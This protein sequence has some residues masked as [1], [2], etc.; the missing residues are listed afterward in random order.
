MKRKINR[1]MA[2]FGMGIFIAGITV[3]SSVIL[4]NMNIVQTDNNIVKAAE[5]KT[6]TETIDGIEWCYR[7]GYNSST[8]VY[9]VNKDT[10]PDEVIIPDKLGGFPVTHIGDK[11]FSE[12]K[13]KS[14]T[15][16]ETVDIIGSSAFADCPNLMTI[17]L[18]EKPLSAAYE[19][20]FK[21]CKAITDVSVGSVFASAFEGCTNLKT[22]KMP[23][24]FNTFREIKSRGFKGCTSLQEVSIDDS[25]TSVTVGSY[26]F[27]GCT[28]LKAF[29]V[30]EA[31]IVLGK[32]AF[33]D[34]TQ[35]SDI[36]FKGN[37]TGKAGVFKNCISLTS[38][39]FEKNATLAYGSFLGCA[40]LEGVTFNGNAISSFSNIANSVFEGCSSLKKVTF[41][42]EKA[43]V[44]FN[45]NT[46]VEEIVYNNTKTISGGL[47][48]VNNLKKVRFDTKNPDLS[49]FT[50][51]DSGNFIIE[52]YRENGTNITFAG[53]DTVYQWAA[54]NNLI[55]SF[56]SLGTFEEQ[57]ETQVTTQPS[58]T[59]API[60][61]SY[62]VTFDG[63]GGFVNGIIAKFRQEVIYGQTYGTLK[64]A[65]RKGYNFKGW[66]TQKTGGDRIT[67]DTK[68]EITEN[69]TLYAQWEKVSVPQ[70]TIS[71]LINNKSKKFTITIKKVSEAEGYEVLYSDSKNF[72]DINQKTLPAPAVLYTTPKLSKGQT[73]YVKVRAYKM[74]ST[75]SKV[76]GKYSS[77]KKI[78]IRK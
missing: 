32:F 75:G 35:F 9:P 33:S 36:V 42:G 8:Y 20:A 73:Y 38:L 2:A 17:K 21:N 44:T 51:S 58:I 65:T 16:P 26:A 46:D 68:A 5:T 7:E 40:S 3:N 56:V 52:G 23:E 72:A 71:K 19:N 67:S 41:N 57:T 54:A 78:K 11:A 31:E 4:Q 53:H 37:V 48:G 34:C 60:I 27:E 25:V 62:S 70:G 49:R 66:Y 50:Y 30:N 64:K 13:V 77:V 15:I 18:P 14:V 76:Y 6:Y 74:D 63:N 39:T 47:D 43:D 22:V 28:S 10:L 1:K 59:A 55:S 61:Q 24:N 29:N 69:I 12:S 45:K